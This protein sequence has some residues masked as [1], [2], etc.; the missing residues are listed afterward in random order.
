MD[1]PV[2]Q[3]L[4]TRVEIFV[5]LF[6]EGGSYIG[7]EPG[8]SDP[9]K[10]PED[11]HRWTVFLLYRKQ[12]AS[13]DAAKSDYTF[14]GYATVYRFFFFQPPT[15]P[16]SPKADWDLPKQE[17]D[18]ADLPCRTRLSQFIILPPFQGK[19]VGAQLYRSIFAHYLKSEQ[20]VELTV[21]DP[22]EAFDDMRDLADLNYL[23]TVPEFGKVA[24]NT[25]IS[26]PSDKSSAVPRDIVDPKLLEDLRRKTKIAPRQ[27]ARLIEMHTMSQ[28]PTSVKPS[29]VDNKTTPTKADQ[30][31]YHLWQLFAKQRIYRQNRDLLGQIDPPERLE[32][33]NESLSSVEL[34][35]AR[36]L[37]AH[38]R[39]ASH[40]AAEIQSAN[41]KRK[42]A[43][44]TN[45]GQGAAKKVR[46]EDA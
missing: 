4:I 26:L 40:Y 9:W 16:A 24:I 31:Q 29:F 28:L 5:P 37:A 15:P 11:A 36:L 38:T 19:G 17:V 20:T 10:A 45:E 6:I 12:P 27:F 1:D 22:N 21:E 42:E 30:H 13:T 43:P 35:Y 33:L 23:R 8:T 2:I 18:M 14:V 39:W 25:A 41:G 32:K 7:R 34:E 3:Q 46:I 44:K